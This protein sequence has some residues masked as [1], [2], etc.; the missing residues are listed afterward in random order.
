MKCFFRTYPYVRALLA[1]K[2][3]TS[4]KDGLPEPMVEAWDRSEHCSSRGVRSKFFFPLGVDRVISRGFSTTHFNFHRAYDRSFLRRDHEPE[5][6]TTAA[7]A[8]A[9]AVYR[10]CYNQLATT[11]QRYRSQ[12][13]Q[14][15][16]CA[17]DRSALYRVK[18][19]WKAHEIRHPSHLLLTNYLSAVVSVLLRSAQNPDTTTNNSSSE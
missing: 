8:A 7:A 14:A 12:Q 5:T 1:K 15:T 11:L 19:L 10:A 16:P 4:T 13:Q 18:L 9:V 17:C 3:S 6:S 2:L